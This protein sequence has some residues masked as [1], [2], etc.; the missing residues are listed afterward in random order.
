MIFPSVSVYLAFEK[1]L[2]LLNEHWMI[3][4]QAN[5]IHLEN[6]LL[7]QTSANQFWSEYQQFQAAL[8]EISKKISENDDQTMVDH[9]IRDLTNRK[10]RLQEYAS[11]L[12][13]FIADNQIE[14]HDIQCLINECE[15]NTIDHRLSFR[16]TL[17][18]ETPL[19]QNRIGNLPVDIIQSL[20]ACSLKLSMLI[21]DQQPTPVS[22]ANFRDL[23]NDIEFIAYDIEQLKQSDDDQEKESFE[24]INDRWEELLKQTN[25][26]YHYLEKQFEQME[27]QQ[28]FY[29][30]FSVELNLL[31]QQIQQCTI[32]LNFPRLIE[33]FE[34]LER[35][36][37]EQ[38]SD[39]P[40]NDLK[41][42]EFDHFFS[43]ESLVDRTF[44]RCE[45]TCI[46]QR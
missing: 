12:C 30:Q 14:T 42:N 19:H 13:S 36:I 6:L 40:D 10:Q 27:M 15:Q 4:K 17:I 28:K 32:P 31:N 3:M 18:Y 37:N 29:E 23:I 35:K 26:Q 39:S 1:R 21:H 5:E 43:F 41:S 7:T 8:E 16:K 33:R 20:D 22:L 46:T 44:D 11:Q 34:E 9:L 2:A 24:S 45:T 38:F 25:E